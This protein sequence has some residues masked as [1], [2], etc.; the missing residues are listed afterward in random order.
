MFH[1]PNIPGSLLNLL[2]ST[3]KMLV[4]HVVCTNSVCGNCYDIEFVVRK[5][6]S[7]DQ[8]YPERLTSLIHVL[9]EVECRRGR[10]MHFF[11]LLG[12]AGDEAAPTDLERK[13]LFTMGP[14]SLTEIR[15]TFWKD[16]QYKIMLEIK[17]KSEIMNC[18]FHL[19]LY[20]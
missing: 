9:L 7:L 15:A 3:L 4:P 20:T 13:C 10:G 14:L 8:L 17:S 16:K 11:L 6:N 2:N 18:I 12:F 5:T 1:F 19:G